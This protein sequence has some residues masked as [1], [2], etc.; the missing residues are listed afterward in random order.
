MVNTR[1]ATR[2]VRETR[3][4]SGS[5]LPSWQNEKVEQLAANRLTMPQDAIASLLQRLVRL[6]AGSRGLELQPRKRTPGNT[7]Y[8]ALENM[9]AI[10]SALVSRR[11]RRLAGTQEESTP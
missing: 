5:G 6:S 7:S 9:L 8:K 11:R 10:E 3:H 2:D 4:G 1:I